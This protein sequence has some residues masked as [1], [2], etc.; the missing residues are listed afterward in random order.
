M[1]W[2]LLDFIVA[3]A[4]I[5]AVG[6]AYALVVRMSAN[7]AYRAAAVVALCAAL[8]LFWVNAAVGIIGDENNDANMLYLGVIAIGVTGALLARFQPHGMSRAMIATAVAQL[9]VPT[10]ALFA[11]YGGEGPAWPWDLIVLTGF[12]SALWLLS[13]WLFRSSAGPSI[14][15]GDESAA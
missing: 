6:G 8:V 9:L 5:A 4:L 1:N 11:G 2:D 3:G 12:F 15:Y 13:A 14:P 10:I 7:N